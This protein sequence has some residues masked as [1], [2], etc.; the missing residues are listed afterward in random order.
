MPY[1]SLM[2][3]KPTLRDVLARDRTVLANER[4]LLAYLR[5]G[6]MLVVAGV[7]LYKLMLEDGIG[8][9]ITAAL[10]GA[11]GLAVCGI[12]VARFNTARKHL[13]AIYEKQQ[14]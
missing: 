2:P 7:T 13:R 5:T 3:V 8:V 12:G 9:V 14:I 10:L 11:I 6:L 4:T 1:D